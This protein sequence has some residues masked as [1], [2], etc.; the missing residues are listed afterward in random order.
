MFD[1]VDE[2]RGDYPNLADLL[3]GCEANGSM[4]ALPPFKLTLFVNEGRLRF[5]CS[6]K[7]YDLWGVGELECPADGLVAVEEALATGRVSW[8]VETPGRGGSKSR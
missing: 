5:S 3:T 8:K 7:D 6:S 1:G 2:F 4:G